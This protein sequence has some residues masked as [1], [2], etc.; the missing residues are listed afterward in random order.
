MAQ[1][2]GDMAASAGIGSYSTPRELAAAVF[3]RCDVAEIARSLL[4]NGTAKGASVRLRMWEKLVELY[5]GKPAKVQKRAEEKPEVEIIWDILP[6][7]TQEP[8]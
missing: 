4:E 6:N 3:R 7:M 2:K 5:F 8:Q 1:Q